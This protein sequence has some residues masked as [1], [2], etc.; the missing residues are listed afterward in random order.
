MN[1]FSNIEILALE[2]NL[3]VLPSLYFHNLVNSYILPLT[4]PVIL[5][6]FQ[7]IIFKWTQIRRLI[8]QTFSPTSSLN[9]HFYSVRFCT[10]FFFYLS[11]GG[12]LLVF[13]LTFF[14][15]FISSFG[16]TVKPSR[17]S[18]CRSGLVVFPTI[19]TFRYNVDIN[20]A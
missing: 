9:I 20:S 17:T 18:K 14:D 8:F 1:G 16:L 4:L 7:K 10:W 5:G 19:C 12:C 13:G 11:P 3:V 15:I 2:L 6:V